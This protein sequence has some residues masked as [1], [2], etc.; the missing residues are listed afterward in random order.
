MLERR[1]RLH[2][3]AETLLVGDEGATALERVADARP[4]EGVQL[5]AER[6][7]VELGVLGV[8]QRHRGGRALVLLPQ[9]V[10]QLAHRLVDAHPGMVVHEAGELE[11]QRGV[12]RHA[13]A[14]RSAAGV[15]AAGARHR[16][17]FGNR[18]EGARG[19][20]VPA[21]EQSDLGLSVV[22]D[23]ER[24]LRRRRPAPGP[25]LAG[26]GP[27]QVVELKPLEVQHQLAA[28]LAEGNHQPVLSHL[29]RVLELLRRL[30]RQNAQHEGARALVHQHRRDSAKAVGVTQPGEDLG[31][32]NQIGK[33]LQQPLDRLRHPWIGGHAPVL[34]APVEPALGQPLDR[35][36]QLLVEGEREHELRLAGLLGEHPDA[37]GMA[38]SLVRGTVE[39][40]TDDS[41]RRTG[42]IASDG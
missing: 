3:L 23:A 38:R 4:L 9:L 11:R 15:E 37:A 1:E 19:C 20:G 28:V 42:P 18:L 35:L 26:G 41:S 39:H 24:E 25:Q 27:C 12:G 6:Q 14:P 29:H 36:V 16:V 33:T 13:D 32:G 22:A 34:A 30:A 2:G 17:G 40:Q 8:G 5:A 21:G 7:P 10:E 31:R